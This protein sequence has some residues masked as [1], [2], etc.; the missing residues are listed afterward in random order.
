MLIS[1]RLEL[2]SRSD[3]KLNMPFLDLVAAVLLRERLLAEDMLVSGS[4]IGGGG[5]MF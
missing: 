3:M 4:G 1:R 5:G 2:F